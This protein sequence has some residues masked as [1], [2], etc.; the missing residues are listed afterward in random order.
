[1]NI[2]LQS[3]LNEQ[4]CLCMQLCCSVLLP[5]N[6]EHDLPLSFWVSSQAI[7]S[8]GFKTCLYPKL[9]HHAAN[10]SHHS[11]HVLEHASN[12]SIPLLMYGANSWSF[13]VPP[14]PNAPS[15]KLAQAF[16]SPHLIT[17][18]KFFKAYHTLRLPL[19]ILTY[20]ILFSCVVDDHACGSPSLSD[21]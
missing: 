16:Q 20:T 5:L 14:L 13:S 2:S 4:R 11:L 19:P 9:I 12:H 18:G 21:G 3:Y 17:D 10:R 6:I 8:R 1:M 15:M 7:C